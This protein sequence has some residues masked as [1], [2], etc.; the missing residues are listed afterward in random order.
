M[1]SFSTPLRNARADLITSTLGSGCKLKVYDASNVL[2][3]TWIW[4]GNLAGSASS[5]VLTFNTPII[6]GVTIA[7]TGTASYGVLT[8]TDDAVVV[9][10][11]SVG[12]SSAA[13]VLTTLSLV[14]GGLA[15]FVSGSY[16]EGNV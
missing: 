8:K 1:A 15:T 11:L 13:I 5:G 6:T 7:A 3:A 16:T 12:T 14:N 4:S 2:L 9:S 10:N